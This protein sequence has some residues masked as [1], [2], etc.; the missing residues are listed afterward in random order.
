MPVVRQLRLC[1]LR[2]VRCARP[3]SPSGGRH[4]HHPDHYRAAGR[5][6]FGQRREPASRSVASLST[7]TSSRVYNP[8]DAGQGCRLDRRPRRTVRPQSMNLIESG[9]RRHS[10]VSGR[11]SSRNVGASPRDGDR[12]AK[13][14]A[15]LLDAGLHLPEMKRRH[16][17][18]ESVAEKNWPAK[19]AGRAALL[20]NPPVPVM[21]HPVARGRQGLHPSRPGA[22]DGAKPNT[23]PRSLVDINREGLRTFSTVR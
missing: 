7:S 8:T 14:V 21:V 3:C 16:E 10:A 6:E 2:C 23:G 1:D 15:M 22:T 12:R 19:V 13:S 4:D 20:A 17:G 11:H 9:R 18:R 5:D